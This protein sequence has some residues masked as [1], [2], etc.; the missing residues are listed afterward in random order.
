MHMQCLRL[1]QILW[2]YYYLFIF[3]SCITQF[4]F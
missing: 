1:Y 2:I 3:H 4:C